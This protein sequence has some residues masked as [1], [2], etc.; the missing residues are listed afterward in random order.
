MS[1]INFNGAMTVENLQTGDNNV[2]QNKHDETINIDWD[3]IKREFEKINNNSDDVELKS[4][5]YKKNSNSFKAWIKK[6]IGS[7]GTNILSDLSSSAIIEI[8]KVFL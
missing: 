7:Y 8:L 6:Y 3:L 1:Q 5:I 4:A 2:Q